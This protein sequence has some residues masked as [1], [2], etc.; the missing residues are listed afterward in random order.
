VAV[1]GHVEP[2]LLHGGAT[3]KALSVAFPADVERHWRVH[4]GKVLV[5]RVSPEGRKLFERFLNVSR[6]RAVWPCLF[7]RI[8]AIARKRVASHLKVLQ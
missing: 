1:I 8:E 3:V 5:Q 4:G 6:P 7:R 2:L